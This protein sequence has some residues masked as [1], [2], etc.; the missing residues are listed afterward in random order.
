MNSHSGKAVNGLSRPLNLLI[1]SDKLAAVQK[2]CCFRRNSLPT[3]DEHG[4][5]IGNG[6]VRD[7]VRE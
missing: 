5:V 4:Q 3:E 6:V 2:Y 1:I 7:E